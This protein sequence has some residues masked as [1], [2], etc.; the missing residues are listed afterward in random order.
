V[1]DTLIKKVQETIKHY[2]MLKDGD[3]VLIA[4][5]SGPDSVCLLHVLKELQ[6][7]YNLSL[8]IAH[9][10]HGFRGEEAEE[11]ARFVQDMGDALGIPVIAEFSDIPAYARTERISKQEA[12]REVR[13]RFLSSAADKTS[14]CRIALGHTA[15][16]QAETFLM[17]LLRGSFVKRSVNTYLFMISV[18]GLIHPT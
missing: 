18:T 3:T 10:N 16:D 1:N 7:E 14:A 8:H 9:L 12:A 17:R 4:V 6:D 2:N 13:Y 5:S 15:D 11:D